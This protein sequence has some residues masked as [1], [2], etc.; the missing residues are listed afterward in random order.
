[1]FRELFQQ[2]GLS[3]ERLHT[4]CLVAGAG[5]VTR[6][7]AGDPNAQSQF[8]R[9][10]KELEEY[11]G[12]ELVRRVGRGLVLTS[13]GKRL[14]IVA[15][16]HLAAL[17]D[18]RAECKNEPQRVTVAAGDSLMH[19]LLLPRL[20]RLKKRLP[21]LAFVFLNLQS[22]EITKRLLEG[23]VDLGLVRDNRYS[24]PLKTASLGTMS[25]WLFVPTS[26]KHKA[27][28]GRIFSEFPL[29]TLEGSGRFR[30]QIEAVLREQNLTLNIKLEFSSFPLLASALR[31]QKM[32]AVLPS[33][34]G[35]ELAG[36]PVKEI[37]HP[38]L[39]CLDRP[40][41]LAWNVRMTR[42]RGAVEAARKVV[43]EEMMF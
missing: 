17:A 26:S 2:S 15:R 32:V 41:V 27:D 35:G 9:Q 20:E 12:T 33:F 16:E 5:S 24:A 39:R 10:I 14:A 8:S 29:A 36:S 4:F 11:F 37:R 40:I 23:T 31:G 18:F 38:M 25:H 43:R 21:C 7:A 1:M 42:I 22:A 6:A 3:L 19:W 28:L 34:A 13:S 30:Q